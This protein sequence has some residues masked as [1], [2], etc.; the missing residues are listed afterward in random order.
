M[1]LSSKT[2]NTFFVFSCLVALSTS[3]LA[4]AENLL[5][6]YQEAKKNDTQLQISETNVLATLEKKPQVMSGLKPRVELGANASYNAQYTDR[7]LTGSSNDSFAN[8]GYDLSLS[9]PLINKQLDA[10]IAQ[11]DASILQ[12]KANL[13]IDQQELIIRVADAYF[14]YLNAEETRTFRKAERTAIGRQ[15]NQ[16][17]AY[18]DAGRSA[19]TDVK[20]AQARYDLANAQVVVAQQLIDVARESLKAITTKYYQKLNGASDNIPLLTPKPNNIDAWE[21]TAIANSRQIIVAQHAI[22]VAQKTVDIE[23]AAKSPI[24][25]LFAKQTGS[26]AFGEDA[27]DQDKLDASVGVNFSMPLFEGGNIASRVREARLRLR[28]S[29][30]QLEL[31]KRLT[32]QQTRA[33][34]LTILSGISQVKAL[35]Q[36]LSSTEAAAKATQAGFEAGTRTA[37][38]VLVSLQETFSAKR[39]YSSARYDFLL[40]TLKLKQANGTLAEKDVVAVSKLL[41]K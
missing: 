24:V 35:K 26:S 11:V 38:D 4:N 19:I 12:A 16:V 23:R 37:V 30:Q 9:K 10:Q 31:Q 36:A 39:D 25:N 7:K 27:F 15:L 34:Y 21:K 33:A 1:S 28:Q 20:E 14:Q 32:A 8:L 40:N 2:G 5:Q 18:F 17:T 6:V 3:S 13:E 29:R 41:T 22:S